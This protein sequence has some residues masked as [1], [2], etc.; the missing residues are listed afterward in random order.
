MQNQEIS[1]PGFV[2][3]EHWSWSL[4][5]TQLLSMIIMITVLVM[6]LIILYRI[7][8]KLK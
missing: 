8:K 6:I 2:I 7:M 1:D 3:L 5:I 4:F